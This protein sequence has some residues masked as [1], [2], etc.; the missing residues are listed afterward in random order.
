MPYA[1]Q[2]HLF[3]YAFSFF[4]NHSTKSSKAAVI[5]ISENRPRLLIFHTRVSQPIR[6]TRKYYSMQCKLEEASS[7]A[8][9]AV[10]GMASAYRALSGA[11]RGT[12]GPG[13]N[14]CWDA[15]QSSSAAFSAYGEGFHQ[16]CFR[17]SQWDLRKIL[18]LKQMEYISY[19]FH[20]SL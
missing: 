6:K 7:P 11:W 17:W 4:L 8:R 14:G 5:F 18:G 19:Y 10:S 16:E 20:G 12:V 3:C 13:G 2:K 1:L 9:G 15:A